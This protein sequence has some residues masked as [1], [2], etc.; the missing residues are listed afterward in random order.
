MTLSDFVDAVESRRMS[1]AIYASEA[2]PD[3]AS[4]FETRNVTVEHETITPGSHQGFV[5]LRDDEGFV[6]AFGL[7][8]LAHLLDPP[9]FRPWDREDLS[10]PWRELY[11][12]LEETLFTSFDRRQLLAAAR[13]IE[14]RAWRVADGTLRVGFQSSEAFRSQVGVYRRLAEETDLT[15]HV[16]VADEWTHDPI[17]AVDLHRCPAEEIG[18]YWL[19]AFDAAGDP[20]YTC[21]LVAEERSPESFYG[22]WTYDPDH[23]GAI[24]SYLRRTYE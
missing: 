24:S 6:G 20:R 15:I 17:P 11:E 9:L 19:L 14:N 10:T 3:V 21:A 18:Q 22:F 7:A 8:E 5:I 1:I 16:Y 23:V 12:V 2:V 4:Q 13:E